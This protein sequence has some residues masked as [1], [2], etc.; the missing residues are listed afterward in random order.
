MTRGIM[1]DD[2]DTTKMKSQLGLKFN[3]FILDN[4]DV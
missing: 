1:D 4:T 3:L 2:S